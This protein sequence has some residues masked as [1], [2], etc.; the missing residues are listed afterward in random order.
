VLAVFAVVTLALTGILIWLIPAIWTQTANLVQRVP[1]YGQRVVHLVSDF[2]NWAHS[3]EER[4]GVHMLPQIPKKIE[5]P[6]A[7]AEET[8]PTAPNSNSA[9]PSPAP[10]PALKPTA[11]PASPAPPSAAGPGTATSA[12]P[13]GTPETAPGSVSDLPSFPPGSTID[14]Q[15][16]LQGDWLRTA[17]P[18]LLRSGWKVLA[19]SFGGVLFLLSMILVPVF[20]YYFLI[21][22]KN[23]AESWDDYLPLRASAFKDEVVATLEEINGY[24]IAFFR[25]QLLV[26]MINGTVTGILL[27]I[28]GLDFGILIGLMLCFFGIIPYLGIT[29]CWVTALIIASTQ[30]GAGTWV[31]GH[32]WILFPLVVSAIFFF[33]QQFDGLFV[34]PKIVGNS[35]GLHPM[36]VMVS[37]FVWSLLL[38]AVLGAILAVPLTA[39]VKVLLRRYVWERRLRA[40]ENAPVTEETFE[41]Q[42]AQGVMKLEAPALK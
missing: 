28:F 26:S 8:T 30:G 29:I 21:E 3:I 18:G 19:N 34:T 37:V 1:T 4:Y 10:S 31:P 36:T 14:L 27:V 23:I 7:P 12:A 35:V 9:T 25:G 33:V 5:N 16:I 41:V 6:L 40:E 32:P 22:S 38:G 11:P 20:L 2:N 42:K 17:V 24:L 13:P 15:S 39:T